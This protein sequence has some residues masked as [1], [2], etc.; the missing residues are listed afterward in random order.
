[1]G[2]DTVR[3]HLRHARKKLGAIN[4]T[5]AVGLALRQDLI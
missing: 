1:M 5:R 4:D 3:G 2:I